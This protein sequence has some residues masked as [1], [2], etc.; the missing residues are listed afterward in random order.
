MTIRT[1][2]NALSLTVLC[3]EDQLDQEISGGYASDMLSCVMAG[4]HKGNVWVTLLT[5]LNVVAVAVLVEIPAVIIT[6]HSPV[7]PTVL[8][9]A[10]TEGLVLLQTPEPTYA[11]V[12]KLYELGVR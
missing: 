10:E 4:A 3:S 7:E 5:H 9:K 2:V 8:K 1:L 12:G 11:V 6:E